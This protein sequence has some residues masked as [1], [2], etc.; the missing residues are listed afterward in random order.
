M[1]AQRTGCRQQ[2]SVNFG[3]TEWREAAGAD[4]LDLLEL[5]V[6]LVTRPRRLV[7]WFVSLAAQVGFAIVAVPVGCAVLGVT[8]IVGG[9]LATLFLS[10]GAPEDI[11]GAVTLAG[12]GGGVILAFLALVRL[13]RAMPGRMRHAIESADDDDGPGPGV[14]PVVQPSTALTGPELAALDAKLA[15]P[16]DQPG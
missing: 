15:P 16:P 1:P 8:T 14:P 4:V 5:L 12:L 9:L 6:N 7:Q 2:A 11:V 13:Y 3:P 10:L